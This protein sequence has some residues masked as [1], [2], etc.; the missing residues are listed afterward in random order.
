MVGEILFMNKMKTIILKTHNTRGYTLVETLVG[1]MVL[2]ICA[3]ILVSGF[4][5]AFTLLRKGSDIKR[6]GLAASSVIEGATETDIVKNTV[7][8]VKLTYQIDSTNYEISGSYETAFDN[9][10]SV[11]FIIFVPDE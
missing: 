1:G 6:K 11:G 5:T 3:A 7:S 4:V 8:G 10:S 2:A 9:T